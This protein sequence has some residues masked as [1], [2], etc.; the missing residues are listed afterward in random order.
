MPER[1]IYERK[2]PKRK[3][4]ATFTGMTERLA[5]PVK[6]ELG[7]L[8]A[9]VCSRG[10]AAAAPERR[11]ATPLTQIGASGDAHETA[12]DTSYPESW[13]RVGLMGRGRVRRTEGERTKN[14]RR[15]PH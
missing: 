5:S 9:G 15:E 14:G 12:H 11:D 10:Y 13:P 7:N 4:T 2:M 6:A 1:K 8:V 3:Q